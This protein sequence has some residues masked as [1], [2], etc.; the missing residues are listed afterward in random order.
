MKKKGEDRERRH[1]PRADVSFEIEYRRTAKER[2]V[3]RSEVHDVGAGGISFVTGEQLEKG[4]RLDITLHL[5]GFERK[6]EARCEVIYSTRAGDG[7]LTAV[8]FSSI[9]YRDFIIVLDYSLAY[10]VSDE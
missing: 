4:E 6:I 8:S 5:K 1:Y 2:N 9:P 10:T 7:Y 3:R